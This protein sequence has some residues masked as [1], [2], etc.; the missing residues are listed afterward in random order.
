MKTSLHLCAIWGVGF[1]I[2]LL[3]SFFKPVSPFFVAAIFTT[4]PL[5]GFFVTIDDDWP[6]GWSN[7]DGDVPFPWKDLITVVGAVLIAWTI[8]A[9]G[10]QFLTP[11]LFKSG[12]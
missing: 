12:A 5:I 11:N 9:L 1:L 10:Q 7:P 3:V 8:Y 2:G 6:R 4:W